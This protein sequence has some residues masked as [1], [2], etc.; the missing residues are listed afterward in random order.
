MY[1]EIAAIAA[2][3]MIRCSGLDAC[4]SFPTTIIIAMATRPPGERLRPAQVAV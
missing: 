2:P 1:I 3:T 4:D